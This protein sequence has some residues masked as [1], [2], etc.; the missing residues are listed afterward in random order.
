MTCT[1]FVLLVTLGLACR[2]KNEA[3][4]GDSR[5]STG[6]TDADTSSNAD[7]AHTENT[8]SNVVI[9]DGPA[10]TN[11]LMI[12]IDTAARQNFGRYTGHPVTLFLDQL[13]EEGVVLEHHRSCSA[14]TFPA[15]TCIVTGARDVDFGFIALPTIADP[16]QLPFGVDTL[17]SSLL[18]V[19]RQT[20]LVTTNVWFGEENRLSWGFEQRIDGDTPADGVTVNL[21]S[22]VDSPAFDPTRPWY[23]HAH[24]M[25]PHRPYS[26]PVEY[27]TELIGRPP[28]PWDIT[29]DQGQEDAAAAFSSLVPAMQDEVLAQ[30]RIV[31]EAEMH[32]V[33]DQ[34]AALVAGL[35]QRGLADD[36]LVVVATDHGEQFFEHGELGHGLTLYGEEN[37]GVAFFWSSN[38]RPTTWE[39]PTSQVDLMP[40]ILDLYDLPIPPTVMGAVAGTRD[41]SRIL[42]SFTT[43]QPGSPPTSAVENGTLKVLYRWDG[44][45]E[46]YRRD[47][48]PEEVNDVYDATDPEVLALWSSLGEDVARFAA[49][50]PEYVPIAPTP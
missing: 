50:Y 30:L 28:L 37:D 20:R 9:F 43:Y 29:T 23:L 4:D 18:A 6:A 26:P 33:D 45:K 10:P 17:A 16:A 32:F 44:L 22:L 19:G 40:T 1:P 11:L 31:Y 12:T 35:E 41:P 21:L 38:I 14:W 27:L 3:A 34:V 36:M 39:E 42:N 13:A 8:G 7:T 48:D 25:D 24:Y 47:E 15:M 2:P 5:D 49:L 46:A